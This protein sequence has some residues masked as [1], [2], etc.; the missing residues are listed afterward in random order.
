MYGLTAQFT[1]S[2]ERYTGLIFIMQK[3]AQFGQYIENNQ[4]NE[5]N[6]T[7]SGMLIV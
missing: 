1:T 3:Y 2:R 4:V 6:I 7:K 5:L